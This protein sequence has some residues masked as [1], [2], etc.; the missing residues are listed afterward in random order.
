MIVQVV[1]MLE[2]FVA[3]FANIVSGLA[4]NQDHVS[5]HIPL[6]FGN[7][8]AQCTLVSAFHTDQELHHIHVCNGLLRSFKQHLTEA[9]AGSNMLVEIILVLEHFVAILAQV[10]GGLSVLQDHV[11]LHVALDPGNFAA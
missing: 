5:L 11:A 4:M 7:F 9:F 8:P 1:F 3:V 6:G 10:I 2:D